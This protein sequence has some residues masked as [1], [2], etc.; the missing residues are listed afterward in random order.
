[1]PYS[2]YTKDEARDI[3]G[4]GQ[5]AREDASHGLYNLV[6]THWFTQNYTIK[7]QVQTH[8]GVGRPEFIICNNHNTPVLIVELKRPAKWTTAGKEEVIKELREYL[9]GHLELTHHN[10]IYGLGGI[11]SLDAVQDEE[12]RGSSAHNCVQ[13]EK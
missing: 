5:G 12:V 6:L 8:R 7:P 9:E 10:T 11:D 13:L 1:M 3:Q 4:L 2:A